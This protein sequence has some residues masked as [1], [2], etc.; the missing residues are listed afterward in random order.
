MKRSTMKIEVDLMDK[1]ETNKIEL[2]KRCQDEIDELKM[3]FYTSFVITQNPN[4][5]L[6]IKK[7]FGVPQK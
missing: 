4:E 2:D 6:N 5:D 1:E 3:L 7:Q